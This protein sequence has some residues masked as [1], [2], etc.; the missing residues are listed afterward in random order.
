M[1]RVLWLGGMAMDVAVLLPNDIMLFEESFDIAW[2][3]LERSG[4]LG[5]S[6]EASLFLAKEIAELM[7]NGER[8]RLLLS[9]F[10]IDAYRVRH[11]TLRLRVIQ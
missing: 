5:H 8:S 2:R 10:A 4:D 7:K 9:N 11:R 1:R 3:V 6:D